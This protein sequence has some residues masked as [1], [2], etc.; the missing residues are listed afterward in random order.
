MKGILSVSLRPNVVDELWFLTRGG[1]WHTRQR[2]MKKSSFEPDAV[3]AALR[4]LVKYGFAR[5]SRGAGRK[6]RTVRTP[7]PG[8]VARLIS[9]LAFEPGLDFAGTVAR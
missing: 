6:I 3:N 7:S 8:S 9:H 5:L 4:F 1:R 2:I